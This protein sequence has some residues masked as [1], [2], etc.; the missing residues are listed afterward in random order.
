[1]ILSRASVAIALALGGLAAHASTDVTVQ[2]GVNP[3]FSGGTG[4]LNTVLTQQGPASLIS[5]LVTGGAGSSGTAYAYAETGTLK[6]SG[7]SEGSLNSVARAIFRDDFKLDIP[8]VAANTP[9]SLE[10][11]LLVGGDLTVGNSNIAA[12]S[13]QVRAD[14]GGGG[15]DLAGDATLY[16]NSPSLGVHGYV[17]DPFGMLST[18]ITIP[19]GQTLPIYVEMT[20]AAQTANDGHGGAL[21]TSAFDLSHTLRWGGTTVW[22]GGVEQTNVLLTSASG[23]NYLL[24]A[25]VPEP[26]TLALALCGAAVLLARRRWTA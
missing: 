18:T 15:Y 6:V 9:V 13:W 16:N 5:G 17:G 19:T 7:T 23:F 8:G 21:A 22:L 10:F 25:P 26:G 24:A 4:P 3:N 14:M 12:A 11:K 20:G 2:L 1:M